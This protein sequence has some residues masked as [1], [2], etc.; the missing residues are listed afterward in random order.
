MFSTKKERKGA[1]CEIIDYYARGQ[2]GCKQ[3]LKAS[4]EEAENIDD[5][6]HKGN[7]IS[8]DF[9]FIMMCSGA[10]KG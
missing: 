1:L 7:K 6:G 4:K 8:R 3:M 10:G 9:Y 5:N 2:K